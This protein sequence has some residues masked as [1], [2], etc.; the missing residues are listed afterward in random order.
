MLTYVRTNLFD[1]PAQTLVN[2]VNTVGVMGKGI[3]LQ[4]RERYPK[5]FLAYREI[6]KSGTLDVG[7]LHLWKDND[8]WILNFPTKT[9]WKNPSKIEYITSGL[10]TFVES[11]KDMGI[12]SI[13][14]PPLGCGNGNLDWLEVK[15]IME[16]YLSKL[17]IQV[18]VHD[19]QV[20][21]GF[22]PEHREKHV[23]RIPTTF[24]EFLVDIRDQMRSTSGN[25]LTLKG[26]SRFC[27]SW[28]DDG[29]ILIDR[30]SGHDVIRPEHIE[31]AWVSLQSGILSVDQFPGRDSQKSKSYLFS[32]LSELP[33]IHVAEINKPQ[34]NAN[35]PAHGLYIKR[36]DRTQGKVVVGKNSDSEQ[37]QCLSL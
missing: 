34:W 8:H 9:T 23:D 28:H 33:Y 32:I 15:P 13:S 11:Y 26:R 27:A 10:D 7:K 4:F 37:Q 21:R 5:M 16:R 25:F 31:W 18:Y 19:K 22:V 29:G 17:D 14:F 30:S 20:T 12:S 36:S 24:E 3:A 2:T 35:I 6:C 1:S